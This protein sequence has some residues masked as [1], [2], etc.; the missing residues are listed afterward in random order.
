[1]QLDNNLTN[2]EKEGCTKCKNKGLTKTHWL[3]LTFSFFILSTSVYGTI[4][5]VK[6]LVNYFF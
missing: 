2:N 1:M 3:M 5:I 6:N 4:Q